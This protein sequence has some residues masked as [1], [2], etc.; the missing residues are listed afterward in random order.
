[1]YYVVG[2]FNDICIICKEIYSIET[3]QLNTIQL[4]LATLENI[5]L[6]I[7]G[8]IQRNTR[9]ETVDIW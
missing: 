8:D 5:K 3:I 2:T 7:I 1:M 4:K 6:L 9:K